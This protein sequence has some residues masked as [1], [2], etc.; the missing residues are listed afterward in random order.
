MGMG[1][2]LGAVRSGSVLFRPFI[3]Q[4]SV[5]KRE[6]TDSPAVCCGTAFRVIR[7]ALA[8]YSSLLI[9]ADHR[10]VARDWR[11]NPRVSDFSRLGCRDR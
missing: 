11:R 3:A 2:L 6:A 9:G 1:D 5:Q 10:D 7:S 8:P 4:D